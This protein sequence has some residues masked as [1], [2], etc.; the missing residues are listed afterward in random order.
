MIY[1]NYYIGFIFNL[2]RYNIT[3]TIILIIGM[4][5]YTS[6]KYVDQYTVSEAEIILHV[7][8]IDEN[9]YIVEGEKDKYSLIFVD[10]ECEIIDNIIKKKEIN[11]LFV[12]LWIIITISI[13]V[14]LVSIFTDEF[15]NLS[16]VRKSSASRIIRTIKGEDGLYYYISYDRVITK[17]KEQIRKQDVSYEFGIRS[18]N[19]ILFYPK[20]E[21]YKIK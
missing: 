5:L 17:R 13:V 4:L 14:F 6:T 20:K 2:I 9:L 1:I 8:D 15:L 10:E 11:G 21:I 12:F 19:D 3:S 7:S 18:L 16:D